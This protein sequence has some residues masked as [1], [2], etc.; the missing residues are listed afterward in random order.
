[1]SPILV[2]DVLNLS[3]SRYH[4]HRLMIARLHR[5]AIADVTVLIKLGL[6]LMLLLVVPSN[7]LEMFPLRRELLL[8]LLLVLDC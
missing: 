8:L 1:M 6:K 3:L 7:I 4:R 5:S 2:T